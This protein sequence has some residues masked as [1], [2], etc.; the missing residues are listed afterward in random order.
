MPR[1]VYRRVI[2]S[3]LVTGASGFFG[4]R[5][6]ERLRACGETVETHSTRD[7]NLVERAP[8]ALGVKHVYHLAAKTFVPAS[9][10]TPVEFYAVNI[11]GTARVLEYCRCIGASFTLVSSYLYGAPIQLPISE[12]HPVAAFNPYGHS[13]LLAEE[14][15]QY[16]HVTFGVPVTIVRPFNLYGPGQSEEFLVPTLIRQARSADDG[17]ISVED[18]RPKRD[19]LYVDDAVDLLILLR[20]ARARGIYNAGSGVSTSVRELAE[21]IM[22]IVGTSKPILSRNRARP[23]EVLDIVADISK[24]RADVGWFPRIALRTGLE[25][26]V[27]AYLIP[28]SSADSQ[29]ASVQGLSKQGI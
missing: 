5:L 25:R 20:R 6:V 8:A 18:L 21:I 14:I 24:A 16:Y 2:P 4:K 9:W 23:N 15:T 29:S 7:G 27:G 26:T 17:V 13:K 11:L 22:E 10:R 28:A 1:K 12:E 3:V 19:Y